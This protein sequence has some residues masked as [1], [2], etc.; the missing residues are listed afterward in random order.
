MKKNL[1]KL[2]AVLLALCLVL[3]ACGSSGSGRDFDD[4]DKGSKTETTLPPTDEELIAGEWKGTIDCGS[5]FADVLAESMGEELAACFDFG[6]VGFDITL[7]F[8]GT[9]SYTLAID[10]TSL[11]AFAEDVLDVMMSGLH[12]YMEDAL[13]EVLGE[14]TLDEYLAANGM[15]FEQLMAASGVDAETLTEQMLSSFDGANTEGTYT[16]EDG[17]LNMDGDV[18]TYEVDADSL[19]IEAPEGV[20]D[21]MAQVLFPMELE[22]IG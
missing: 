2:F 9:D 4:D 20:E 12:T 13:A 22:R 7:S 16:L 21:E 8:D 1:F 11:E 5:Y 19:T 18:H 3:C 15:D 17:K 6:S 14:Q 10:Q